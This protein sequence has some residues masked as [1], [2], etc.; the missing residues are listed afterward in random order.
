MTETLPE[1][2]SAIRTFSGKID[3]ETRR[4]EHERSAGLGAAEDDDFRVWHAEA[5]LFGFAAVID[6]AEGL[7]SLFMEGEQQALDSF[8]DRVAAR[9]LRQSR[10]VWH[11][12]LLS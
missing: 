8:I 1:A 2:S 4:G 5:S 9:E 3:G 10:F 6:E 12:G 7:Q 11:V